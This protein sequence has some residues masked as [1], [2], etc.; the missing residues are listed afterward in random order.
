MLGRPIEQAKAAI[1]SCLDL[2]QPG[3]TFQLI[4]F[5]SSASQ[6]G[7]APIE[8]TQENI[9][10]AKRYLDALQSEGGTMMI[11]GIKAALDFPHDPERF[12]FVCFLTDGYI[13]NE[14]EIFSAIRAR[15]DATRIFSFG[16]GSSVN[17]YLLEGMARMGKGAVAYLGPRDDGGKVM[18]D[19]FERI[20]HPAMA[21]LKMDWSGLKVQDLFP[22][23]IPDLFVGRPVI[24]TGRYEGEMPRELRVTGRIGTR[25]VD[26]PM[27]VP[28]VD[29]TAI[30][31]GLP[32][33]WARMKLADLSD[34]AS[35]QAE[36]DFVSTARQVALDFNLVSSW[37][38]FV[39]VDSSTRTSGSDATTVPVAVPVPEGVNYR[40]TVNE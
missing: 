25:A 29:Q 11:E 37:T 9:G 20:S 18:G 28:S 35:R 17:R 7:P 10:M 2:L 1:R 30:H 6:L 13:G 31:K 4:N 16:V 24:L 33:V 12:R 38:A 3:D 8:A 34:F 5:S 21:D 36:D 26:L 14:L 23:Q 27:K 32:S 15:L 19:F 40:T 22:K 39:A